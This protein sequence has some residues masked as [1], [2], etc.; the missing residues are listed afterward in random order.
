MTGR[1]GPILCILVDLHTTGAGEQPRDY[2]TQAVIEW[3]KANHHRMDTIKSDGEPALVALLDR[4]KRAR[5]E[6]TVVLRAPT[7][8]SQTMGA[9]ERTNRTIKEHFRVI[10]FQL[11]AKMGGG[12]SAPITPGMGVAWATLPMGT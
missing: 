8:S 3:L 6:E 9:A 1:T 5:V 11:E 2:P 7:R 4:V 10:R 12:A